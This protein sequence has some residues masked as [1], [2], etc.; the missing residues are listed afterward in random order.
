MF[1]SDSGLALEIDDSLKASLALGKQKGYLTYRQVNQHLP[2]DDADP[3]RLDQLLALFEQQGIELLDESEAEDRER[4]AESL[5]DTIDQVLRTLT[6]RER[7]TIKL[8]YG[9][10]DG[11]TCTPAEVG[12][13]FK[14]SPREA[15]DIERRAVRKLQH[16]ARA[17]ELERFRDTLT[18]G[19]TTPEEC[20]LQTVLGVSPGP[21]GPNLFDFATSER[22]QDAFLS[23]LIAWAQ[24]HPCQTNQPLHR[25]GVLF[26]NR[27]LGLHQIPLP[28]RYKHVRISRYKHIDI[29]VRVNEDIVVLI[30]DAMDFVEPTGHL[31]HYLAIVRN[32]FQEWTPVPVYLRTGD[33]P[34]SKAIEEAGWKCFHRRDLLEVLEYGR[35]QGVESDIFRDFHSRLRWTEAV[36]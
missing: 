36:S 22:C 27:L 16:P 34:D 31:E 2:D 21:R 1:E 30:K 12:R 35:G 14:V 13:I 11:H 28:D 23:W 9:L 25:T 24:H 33:Q 6:Y 7:E 26:L 4:S 18:E 3:D 17:R 8:R 10:G 5:K 29:L 19:P 15:R 32:D 20:L